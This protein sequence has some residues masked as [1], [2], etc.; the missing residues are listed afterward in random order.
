MARQGR[1]SRRDG[2]RGQ[3]PALVPSHSRADPVPLSTSRGDVGGCWFNGG[4][5]ED[6]G[7]GWIPEDPL[8]PAVFDELFRAEVAGPPPLIDRLAQGNAWSRTIAAERFEHLDQLRLEEEAA[9][10]ASWTLPDSLEWRSLR[11]EVAAALEVHERSAQ[12]LLGVARQLVH[13][14][15]ATLDGLRHGLF[16]ERHARIL[17]EQAVGLPEALLAEYEERLLPFAARLV[18]SRFERMARSLA[19]TLEPEAMITRHREA[20]RGRT[21]VLEP[22]PNGMVW[23][24]GFLEAM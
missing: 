22:C 23:Y 17:V 10:G 15:P 11:A 12:A 7:A 19:D 14:F 4:M 20:V 13:V 9:T 5:F 3:L 21:T 1:R 18:P 6:D 2:L 16:S 8:D 24:G